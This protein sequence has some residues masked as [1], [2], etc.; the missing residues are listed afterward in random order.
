LPVVLTTAS[1][2]H[3]PIDAA[4]LSGDQ[5]FLGFPPPHAGQHFLQ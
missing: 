1:N 3:F 5:S 4:A 2:E